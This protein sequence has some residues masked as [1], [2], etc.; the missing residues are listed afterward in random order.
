M[1]LKLSLY[2]AA[3]ILY[4]KSDRLNKKMSEKEFREGIAA[5]IAE[6]FKEFETH[7]QVKIIFRKVKK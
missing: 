7:E 2:L 3:Y 1:I 6:G 4:E 5:I